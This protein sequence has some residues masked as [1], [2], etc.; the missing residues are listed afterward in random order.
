MNLLN[1][2]NDFYNGLSSDGLFFFWIV[3]FLFV[4]LL[5]LVIVLFSK[6]RKLMNLIKENSSDNVTDTSSDNENSVNEVEDIDLTEKPSI[7]S[8]E[9]KDEVLEDNV[10]TSMNSE[11]VNSVNSSDND[12]SSLYK[13]NVF[14]EMSRQTSPINIVKNDSDIKDDTS[15]FSSYT[16]DSDSDIS[17]ISPLNSMEDKYEASDTMKSIVMDMEK[18]VKPSNI[19]LTEYEKKQEE[20]AIISYDELQK[21]KDKIYNITE[22]ED[23]EDFIDELKNFRMDL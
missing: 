6:N 12:K 21:V 3:V 18:E 15:T 10:I 1:S 19:E 13:K 16:Y 8:D 4:F 11:E 2:F 7:E 22:D 20:E 17:D 9:V 5:F 14:K 23:N